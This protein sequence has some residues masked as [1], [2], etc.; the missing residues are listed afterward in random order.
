MLQNICSNFYEGNLYA[1]V[2]SKAEALDLIFLTSRGVKARRG[3][4]VLAQSYFRRQQQDPVLLSTSTSSP[5]GFL[6]KRCCLK[7]LGSNPTKCQ[8]ARREKDEADNSQGISKAMGKR[9]ESL[10]SLESCLVSSLE[11]CQ[12]SH[13]GSLVHSWERG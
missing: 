2:Y 7:P 6:F 3:L 4:Q 11:S 12:I 1:S 13:L 9:H 10:V 5:A 8:H